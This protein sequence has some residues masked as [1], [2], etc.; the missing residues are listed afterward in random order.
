MKKSKMK[1]PSL[2]TLVLVAHMTTPAGQP[3]GEGQA[4]ANGQTS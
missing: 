4:G 2:L 3:N 1:F